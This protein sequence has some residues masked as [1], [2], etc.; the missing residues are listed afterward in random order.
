MKRKNSLD[1]KITKIRRIFNIDEVINLS[2]DKKYIQSYYKKNSWAYSL[3]HNR[4]D[5]I[6]MGI[7]KDGKY[8]KDDLLEAARIVES[9][10]KTETTDVL[11]LATGRGATSVYLAKKFPKINFE[12]VEL[13]P[14]HLVYAQKKAKKRLNYHPVLGDYHNLRNY[15]KES[16]DVVFVIEALCHSDDKK[17]VFEEVKRVLKSNGIFVVIDGYYKDVKKMNKE[18]KMASRLVEIGMAVNNF[19]THEELIE[20]SK[21]NG[22]K[23]VKEEN[24]S[25]MIMPTLK[26]F[27]KLAEKFFNHPNGAKLIIKKFPKEFTYNAI[28]GFLM[29][30][31]IRSGVAEYW[32]TVFKK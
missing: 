22:F 23:L 30:D 29:T 21:I 17:R 25:K 10:I 31:L 6:H 4:Q 18:E 16:F 26:R 19:G 13:S 14:G 32:I 8:K 5:Q 7:S 11:E 27:E 3:F 1:K 15:K 9:Y 12:G 24:V 2:L 28:S 20:D